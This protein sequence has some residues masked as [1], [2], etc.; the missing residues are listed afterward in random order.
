MDRQSSG[1]INKLNYKTTNIW[2]PNPK[3][4][5]WAQSYEHILE[6]EGKIWALP[7]PEKEP[8]YP[9]YRRLGTITNIKVTA[10]AE[11]WKLAVLPVGS[12]ILS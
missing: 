6:N 10:P 1:E 9:L 2:K 5:I 3:E 11:N 7:S 12:N 8:P 4:N